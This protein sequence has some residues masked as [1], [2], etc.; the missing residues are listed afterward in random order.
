MT[1]PQGFGFDVQK[2]SGGDES[3]I[4]QPL[5]P[6]DGHLRLHNFTLRVIKTEDY[7]HMSDT[8]DCAEITAVYIVIS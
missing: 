4:F 2:K 6:A 7:C 1:V 5:K 3:H 8:V